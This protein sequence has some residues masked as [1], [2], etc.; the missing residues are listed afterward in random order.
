MNKTL[1]Q[2]TMHYLFDYVT[3]PL[4]HFL[5]SRQKKFPTPQKSYSGDVFADTS[6]LKQ[7]SQS[8]LS[9]LFFK[10]VFTYYTPFPPLVPSLYH[11]FRTQKAPCNSAKY[12]AD[13][14][15][16]RSQLR[17]PPY[18]LCEWFYRLCKILVMFCLFLHSLFIPP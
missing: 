17:K 15:N 1:L 16:L 5:Q 12:F 2:Q 14:A 7:V 18:R 3:H 10:V 11:L 13:S 8:T 4:S 6:S 9:T